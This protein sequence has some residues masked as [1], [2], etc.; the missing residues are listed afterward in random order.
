MAVSK[1]T[2][3]GH[4]LIDLTGDTAVAADVLT[5]KK[6]HLADGT[7][8]TGT[9]TGG[10]T[11]TGTINITANGTVDVTS[12]ASANVAVP[13][14]S[15]SINISSNGS[16]DVTAYATAVVNV[17]GGNAAFARACAVTITLDNSV[18]EGD[19]FNL[20]VKY[21]GYDPSSPINVI[22]KTEQYIFTDS[23][24]TV[25]KTIYLCPIS[26]PLDDGIYIPVGDGGTVGN[27]TSAVNAVPRYMRDTGE[28]GTEHVYVTLSGNTASFNVYISGM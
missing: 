12:Y 10:I 22:W 13:G 9:N 16:H 24:T 3:D 26:A 11:P 6:F 18:D 8:A 2:Y 15:G 19:T 5:G 20:D 25:T 17:S 7:Q 27:I 28:T 14:A 21:R 23:V 1:V 4:T